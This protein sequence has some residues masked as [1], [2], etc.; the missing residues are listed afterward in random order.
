MRPEFREAFREAIYFFK[1][2]RGFFLSH[3]PDCQNYDSDV[4]RV[5]HLRLCK[6][7]FIGYGLAL[8]LFLLFILVQPVNDLFKQIDTLTLCLLGVILAGTQVLRVFYQLNSRWF[9]TLQKTAFGT[10]LFFLAVS[11][12]LFDA[13][14]LTK[15]IIY[16]LS[17][18]VA[19][20][21][22]SLARPYYILKTCKG[23]SWEQ[24]WNECPGF[25]KMIDKD[26]HVDK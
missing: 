6:G 7:C 23:C 3:H 17:F 13:D 22:L 15:I 2:L 16:A 18:V 9:K 11:L 21:V 20:G 8:L 12:V 10:G 1:C 5:G 19:G 25:G 4:I 14:L 26:H 24:N